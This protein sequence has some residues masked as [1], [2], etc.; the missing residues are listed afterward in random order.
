VRSIVASVHALNEASVD[1]VVLARGG[2]SIEDLWAY[3]EEAVARA[4]FDSRVPVVSAV[5]HETDFTIADF[6]AD[7]RAPTPSVAGELLVPD[8]V[9]L[10]AQVDSLALRA[11]R[12][13]KAQCWVTGNDLAERAAALQRALRQRL[14]RESARLAHAEARLAALNPLAVLTRG[15]AVVV[16]TETREVVRSVAQTY[17]EQSLDV[18]F[19]DGRIKVKVET[20]S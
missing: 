1:V 10:A 11:D 18:L 16:D 19:A 14:D 13:I 4:I 5:G 8:A 3:N 15:Y 2:G 7:V 17:R 6:A 9:A 20:I 12:A